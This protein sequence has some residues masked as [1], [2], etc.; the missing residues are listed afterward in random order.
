MSK[1]I[2]KTI[3]VQLDPFQFDRT[4]SQFSFLK[5]KNQISKF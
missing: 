4:L 2:F 5:E 3:R 1:N